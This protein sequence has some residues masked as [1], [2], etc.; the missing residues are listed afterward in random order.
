[1][2][3]TETEWKGNDLADND[4]A[5][6]WTIDNEYTSWIYLEFEIASNVCV[7]AG[8][9]QVIIESQVLVVQLLD[10]QIAKNSKQRGKLCLKL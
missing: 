8:V 9:L 2:F 6:W 1:M 7:C 10:K 4:Q 3:V 5:S